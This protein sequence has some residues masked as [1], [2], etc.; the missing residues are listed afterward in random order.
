MAELLVGQRHPR[1]SRRAIAACNDYLLM[2][3]GRSIDILLE[4]YLTATELPPTHRVMTLKDWSRHYG[5]VKRAEEYDAVRDHE[6]LKGAQ[7]E[8]EAM[9]KRHIQALTGLQM[10]ALERLRDLNASELTPG[11]LRQFLLGGIELE[12]KVRGLPTHIL[13]MGDDE[14]LEFIRRGMAGLGGEGEKE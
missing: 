14:L 10:R 3:P 5:W 11:E 1:E 4:R 6:R 8:L 9:N 12:R 7:D 2:G 13:A